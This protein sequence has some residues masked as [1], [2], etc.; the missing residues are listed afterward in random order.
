VKIAVPEAPAAA[1]DV[2]ERAEAL[3]TETR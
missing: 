1:G 3:R 2:I